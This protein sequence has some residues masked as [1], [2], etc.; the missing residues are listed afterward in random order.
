[1]AGDFRD[2]IDDNLR[3]VELNV[4]TPTMRCENLFF[5]GRNAKEGCLRGNGFGFM[6]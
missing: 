3:L 6:L 2:G 5:V 4:G 1:M